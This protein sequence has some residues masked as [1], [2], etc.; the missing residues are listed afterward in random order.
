MT[1]KIAE[2]F[3]AYFAPWGITLP[4]EALAGRRSGTIRTQ[5]WTIQYRFD[6]DEQGPFLDFYAT[7]RMTNDR[8]VRI[9]A[10]GRVEHLLSYWEHLIYPPNATPE[11]KRLAEQEFN[12]YNRRVTNLLRMKGFLMETPIENRRLLLVHWNQSEAAG[13]AEELRAAGWEVAVEHGAADFKLSQLRQNP[14]K[15]VLISLRR[16]PS[17]GRELADALW[18]T[19]WGRQIPLIFFDGEADKAATLQARFPAARFARWEELPSLLE[20]L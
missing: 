7:H 19:Q 20:R 9:H 1:G 10:S 18:S 2:T 15:A 8:H 13:L 12:E 17:H 3:A 4:E 14:P 11:Q 16:L 6:A 5:G